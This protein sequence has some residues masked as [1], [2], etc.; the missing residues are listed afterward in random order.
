MALLLFSLPFLLTR[1]GLRQ[2]S[3]PEDSTLC[4]NIM[5][6]ITDTGVLP[7]VEPTPP[8]RLAIYYGWPSLVNGAQGN[9][10]SATHVFS[11][12]NVVVFGD[13]LEHPTHLEHANTKI[14]IQNLRKNEIEVYGYVDLGVSPPTQNLPTDTIETYVNE[15]AAMNVTGIFYDDAGQ[16]Y[17]VTTSRL[18][19]AINY[20]H[21]QNL[22]VFINAWNPTDVFTGLIPWQ[23][24]DWYLAESHPVT[25]DRC[26]HLDDWQRKSQ[27]I[28]T[29]AQ[30]NVRIAAVSTGSAPPP[31]SDWAN[32]PP[33]KQALLAAY[34]FGFDAIGFTNP[35][36]SAC[37]EGENHLLP[38]PSASADAGIIDSDMPLK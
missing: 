9:L 16:D 35:H 17:G 3:K 27:L 34:L 23:D 29:R 1:L 18:A 21:A 26:D 20:A 10:I 28:A 33:F 7:V 19:Q 15:W 6:I 31:G 24:G 36:Y 2:N 38:L 25:N 13:G 11:Q 32:Y 4:I 8:A 14:I 5:A 22:A 30:T 37:C 12:F